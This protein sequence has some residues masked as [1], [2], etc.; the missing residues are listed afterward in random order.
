MLNEDI[1]VC[2]TLT[3]N[4]IS[5]I[6]ICFD[7]RVGILFVLCPIKYRC[8]STE[9]APVACFYQPR[10][11]RHLAHAIMTLV[12]SRGSIANT[13][14]GSAIRNPKAPDIHWRAGVESG[15]TAEEKISLNISKFCHSHCLVFSAGVVSLFSLCI[16]PS[17]FMKCRFLLGRPGG[18]SINAAVCMFVSSCVIAFV[19]SCIISSSDIGL[20]EHYLYLCRAGRQL[21]HH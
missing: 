13:T 21:R 8:T 17:I 20:T 12:Y 14:P 11:I 4:A 3:W 7:S 16:L 10:L 9:Y 5:A 19:H 15:P 18:V 6:V 2:F 1:Y